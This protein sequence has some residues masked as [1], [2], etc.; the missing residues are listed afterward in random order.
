M[1]CSPGA[2]SQPELRGD[3]SFQLSFVVVFLYQGSQDAAA[4]APPHFWHGNLRL[5]PSK[6]TLARAYVMFY[7]EIV[8][9]YSKVSSMLLICAQYILGSCHVYFIFCCIWRSFSL[10]KLPFHP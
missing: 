4:Q 8:V 1:W 5:K 9:L 7:L 2:H 6:L 3:W 10:A